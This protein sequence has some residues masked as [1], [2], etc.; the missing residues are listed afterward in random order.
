MRGGRT[1]GDGRSH[2]I[3][4]SVLSPL[5]I[6]HRPPLI[7]LFCC[8]INRLPQHSGHS[9]Q[10]AGPIIKSSLVGG[11]SRLAFNAID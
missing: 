9:A 5:F 11:G 3:T 6:V 10:S 8:G 7:F 4:S 1:T 2:V